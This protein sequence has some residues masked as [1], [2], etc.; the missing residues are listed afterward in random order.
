MHLEEFAHGSSWLHRLDPR[1]KIA[2]AVV[3][4]AIAAVA[5]YFPVLTAA[6]AAG[7]FLVLLA[8][9]DLGRVMARLAVV[10]L[11]VLFLWLFLPFSFPGRVVFQLGP[12]TASYEGLIAALTITLKSNAIMLAGLALLS[13]SP[14]FA[15]VHALRHLGVPD[16]LV[17]LFFFT[18]RYFQV[19]HQEYLRLRAAMKVRG[20]RPRTNRHTYRS[21][22]YL[23]GMLL[24]RS[25]DRSER[26]YQAMLCRGYQGRFWLLSHFH[27][28]ARDLFFLGAFMLFNLGLA[29]LQ[30]SNL[31]R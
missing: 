8:G 22:A 25:F 28:H 6:L 4:S 17:N 3:F 9:L 18:Y 30:W 23:V 19:V 21:L 7:I 26:V 1:I 13:T 15:L 11:F 5:D 29:V 31:V 14:V 10:N 24:V 20:F 12:L 2:A 27:L 16:K